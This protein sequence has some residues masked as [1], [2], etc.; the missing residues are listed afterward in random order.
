LRYKLRDNPLP[1]SYFR[2][3]KETKMATVEERSFTKAE[4]KMFAQKYDAFQA[5]QKVVD[6][7][8]IFLREQHEIPEGE[9]GWQIG[10][11]GFFRMDKVTAE[12][13][14]SPTPPPTP[15]TPPTPTPPP[16]PP[17]SQVV[18]DGKASAV[19]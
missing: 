3:K 8:V 16:T 5:A 17:P 13:P 1:K 12:N 2:S 7:F 6:E 10:Q 11:N 4:M 9:E 14:P 19:G 15:P 18:I